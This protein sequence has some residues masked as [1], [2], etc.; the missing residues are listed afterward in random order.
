MEGAAHR[1]TSEGI[2]SGSSYPVQGSLGA[3]RQPAEEGGSET[4]TEFSVSYEV[5]DVLGGV[6]QAEG[7][8]VT[9]RDKSSSV[10]QYMLAG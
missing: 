2:F 1:G 3:A 4:S 6:E 5:A 9:S 8:K 10:G 7:A